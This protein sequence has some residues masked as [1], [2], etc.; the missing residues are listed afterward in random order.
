VS[1]PLAGKE[2]MMI[3]ST[4]PGDCGKAGRSLSHAP[5]ALFAFAGMLLLVG[6]C[7]GQVDG[8]SRAAGTDRRMTLHFSDCQPGAAAGCAPGRNSNSG[9]ADSP[10]QNLDGINLDALPAGSRLLFARGGAWELTR[11]HR[12]E[13]LQATTD[14]PLTFADYGSGPLPLIRI[15]L[16]APARGVSIGFEIGGGWNNK[17]N[18]GGYVFRNLRFDG[19][20]KTTWGFW[21]RDNVHDVTF[22]GVEI[23]GFHIGIH[24][25]SAAPHGVTNVALLNSRIVRNSDMGWLGYPKSGLRMEGNTFEANNA[26]GSG[27]SHAVYVGGGDNSVFRNNRFIRNSVAPSGL[28]TGGSLTLHGQMT[29]ILVE[30][31]TFE[32]TAGDQ[33]CWQISIT[34]G[35][36]GAEWFRNLVVRGNTVINGG[37]SGMVIQSAPGALVENNRIFNTQ[38]VIPQTAIVVGGGDYTGGDDADT[39]AIVRNNTACYTAP[40]SGSGV[41]RVNSSGA[42]VVNNSM[43]TGKAATTGVCAR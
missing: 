15:P 24:T 41:T 17:T 28:C 8:G 18:D 6:G 39:G 38:T 13:N 11:M 35:Y 7:A 12:L 20:G 22:D 32:Q 3:D 25:Q 40:A 33:G 9:S 43:L 10:K 2:S 42:T 37:N 4:A 16:P 34:Q 31:N 5:S 1:I 14:L 30:G 19:V 27:F 26:S 29:G 23:G 21:L 36:T